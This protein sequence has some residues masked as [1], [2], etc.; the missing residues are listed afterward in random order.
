M[1]WCPDCGEPCFCDCDDT[2]YREAPLSGKCNHVCR[3]REE[4]IIQKEKDNGN[5]SKR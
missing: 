3:E 4:D 5:H 1:H 2:D